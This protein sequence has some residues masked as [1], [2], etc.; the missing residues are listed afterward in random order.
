MK[1]AKVLVPA[2]LLLGPAVALGDLSRTAL[3]P[4]GS[5]H[6]TNSIS[7]NVFALGNTRYVG[8]SVLDPTTA[9]IESVDK[10]FVPDSA[11]Y[12]T[13]G[14]T[15]EGWWM[16]GQS[17]LFEVTFETTKG[18]G[19]PESYVGL[20]VQIALAN[21]DREVTDSLTLMYAGDNDLG[22]GWAA[23]GKGWVQRVDGGS[24]DGLAPYECRAP[25]LVP[26]PGAVALAVLGLGLC[27]ARRVREL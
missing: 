9:F 19:A 10:A 21:A 17:G 6:F 18:T 24:W 16:L 5:P 14:K 26:V 3:Q 12:N 2:L 7:Q 15:T 23:W 1:F 4:I 8:I 11:T 27:G 20:Q 22:P 25:I 13:D